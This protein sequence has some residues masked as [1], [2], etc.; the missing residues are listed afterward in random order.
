MLEKIVEKQQDDLD[1]IKQQ[2]DIKDLKIQDTVFSLKESET[3]LLQSAQ[4]ESFHRSKKEELAVEV[5][6]LKE[7]IMIMK[8]ECE[9]ST[10]ADSQ[11]ADL[12][13]KFNAIAHENKTL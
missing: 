2:S 5:A 13:M 9:G 8:Q 11:I 7:E 10:L 3:S 4:S 1:K 6:A 12:Q